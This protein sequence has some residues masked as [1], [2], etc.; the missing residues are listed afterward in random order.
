MDRP[1]ATFHEWRTL[2]MVAIGVSPSTQAR[3]SLSATS[4]GSND[5]ETTT[6]AIVTTPA[7]RPPPTSPSAG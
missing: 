7:N 3:A 4:G 2:L 1:L 6:H 5:G